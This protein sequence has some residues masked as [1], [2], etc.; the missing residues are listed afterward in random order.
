MLHEFP[1]DFSV[2]SVHFVNHIAYDNAE[3]S[4]RL[5][6]DTISADQIYQDYYQEMA[7]LIQ[8]GLFHGLAHPDTIKMFHIQPAYDLTPTYHRIAALL[9]EHNMYTENNVGCYYRYH[10]EDLGLSDAFLAILLAHHV[11]LLIASDAHF[12]NH[13]GM[14]SKEAAIRIQKSVED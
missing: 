8:S 12:P 14:Y 9:V 1:Y 5:L 6:W 10:H 7:L 2:G 3:F 4:K 11:R 13:V